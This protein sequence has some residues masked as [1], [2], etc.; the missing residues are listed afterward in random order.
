MCWKINT[1]KFSKNSDKYHK[2]ADKNIIVYKI[3]D[4]RCDNFFSACEL[5]KYKR[6]FSNKK[7]KLKLQELSEDGKDFYTIEKGY[8]SY[9]GDCKIIIDIMLFYSPIFITTIIL[10]GKDEQK[11]GYHD[12]HCVGIFIIPKGSEY[13]ENEEGEIVSNQLIWSGEYKEVDNQFDK[14]IKLRNICVGV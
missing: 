3:G 4:V 1:I 6:K 9:S 14:P 7:T 10:K 8:H 13:Y 11:A 2:I 5:Y 12:N